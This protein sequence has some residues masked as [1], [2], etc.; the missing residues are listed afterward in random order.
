[1]KIK[2]KDGHEIEFKR[3]GKIWLAESVIW[4]DTNLYSLGELL[5]LK[6]KIKRWFKENAPKEISDKFN[7]RLPLW[8]EIHPLPF[9]D[10]V[11]Y[12]E[13]KTDQI[14]DYFLGDEGD[15]YP[16]CCYVGN[17]NKVCRLFYSGASD[18]W[19]SSD[20]WDA[21]DAIRLCLEEKE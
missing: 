20:D 14:A 9:K 7:A 21:S 12:R 3:F 18:D 8:K 10:Q 2:F 6:K 17:S 13:G 19:D 4:G 16:Y 5:E 11:A 1:M 15:I